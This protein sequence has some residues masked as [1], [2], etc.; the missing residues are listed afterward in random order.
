MVKTL[1]GVYTVCTDISDGSLEADS[2]LIFQNLPCS[3]ANSMG[4][5]KGLDAE[6]VSM[7]ILEQLTPVIRNLP[8]ACILPDVL[9]IRNAGNGSESQIR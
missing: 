3:K 2:I 8:G 6:Y 9:L 7:V 1:I 4:T 5:L